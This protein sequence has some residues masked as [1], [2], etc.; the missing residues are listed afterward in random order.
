MTQSDKFVESAKLEIIKCLDEWLFGCLEFNKVTKK[1]F[2]IVSQ[3]YY[4]DKIEDIF[5]EA[6]SKSFEE[7]RRQGAEETEVAIIQGT[8]KLQL[9]PSFKT[10]FEVAREEGRQAENE[11]ILKLVHEQYYHEMPEQQLL[12]AI[13]QRREK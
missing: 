9:A 12:D 5:S 10:L 4:L 2:N 13:R 11:R 3:G 8:K 7:G 1:D 6:I